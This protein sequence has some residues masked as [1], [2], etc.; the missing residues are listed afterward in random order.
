MALMLPTTIVLAVKELLISVVDKAPDIIRAIKENVNK[1][2]KEEY[3]EL[4]QVSEE[5]GEVEWGEDGG[6]MGKGGRR[7]EGRWRKGGREGG[8][9]RRGKEDGGK[10]EG[11]EGR[12][13]K[14]RGRMDERKKGKREG[15][16]KREGG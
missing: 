3:D 7:R 11:K 8:K 1:R 14:E 10:E 12:G 5:K 9:E 2:P 16:K 15:E 6:D 4:V 13:Q